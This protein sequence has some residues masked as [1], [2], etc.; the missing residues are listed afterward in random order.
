MLGGTHGD[1]GKSPDG[2]DLPLDKAR[3]F[4]ARDSSQPWCLFVT[5]TSHTRPESGRRFR[6]SA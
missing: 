4:M 3:E 5:S 6:L 2:E 1:S